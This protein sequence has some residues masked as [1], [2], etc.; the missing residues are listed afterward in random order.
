MDPARN[1][2]SGASSGKEFAQPPLRY[3]E[4][5]LGHLNLG[6]LAKMWI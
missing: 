4:Q 5:D 2:S 3:F 6:E 1:G